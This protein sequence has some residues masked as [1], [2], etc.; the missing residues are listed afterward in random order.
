MLNGIRASDHRWLNKGRG[1]KFR[2]G[3]CVRQETHKEGRRTY[4]PKLCEYNNKY[5]DNDPEILTEKNNRISS[6]L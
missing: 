1:L 4:R 6:Q 5:K 2:V 3:S